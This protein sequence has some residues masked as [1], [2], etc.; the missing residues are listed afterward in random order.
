MEYNINQLHTSRQNPL[1]FNILIR[2]MEVDELKSFRLVGGT[3]LAL[4]Y[5]HRYSVDIDMFTD[6]E[7][8]TVDFNRVE[9][10]LRGLFPYFQ[11]PAH[12]P[13]AFG[14]SFFVGYSD[15]NCV[16]VDLMYT[17]IFLDS[18][19]TYGPI[20]MATRKDIAAMKMEAVNT[21]PRKKDFWDVH[22]LLEYHSLDEM[23]SFHQERHPYTHNRPELLDKMTTF[24]PVE[25][26]PDPICYLGKEWADIKLD[27]LSEVSKLI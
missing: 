5:D 26:E 11:T 25:D 6:S 7:Y 18:P 15:D 17:D 27:I 9:S 20:R 19:D 16:K 24:E 2:L 23:L 8:G 21:G 1:L 4:V 13:A 3:N 22:F 12:G 14:K 10:L